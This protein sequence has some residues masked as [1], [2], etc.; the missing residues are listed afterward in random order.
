ML[1]GRYESEQTLPNHK[2]LNGRWIDKKS[3]IITTTCCHA[4]DKFS[5]TQD[6][7][8]NYDNLSLS[9]S[10]LIGMNGRIEKHLSSTTNLEQQQQVCFCPFLKAYLD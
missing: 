6:D 7:I 2:M 8:L 10:P 9:L 5:N 1:D 3:T 4:L